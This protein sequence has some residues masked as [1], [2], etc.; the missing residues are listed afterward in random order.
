MQNLSIFRGV[1]EAFYGLVNL[2]PLETPHMVAKELVKVEFEKLILC[3]LLKHSAEFI[4]GL[5]SF[6]FLAEFHLGGPGDVWL[7]SLR[8]PYSWGWNIPFDFVKLDFK[9]WVLGIRFSF[10]NSTKIRQ[11][12]GKP[13][14][15]KFL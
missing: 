9:F 3:K 13:I 10:H 4:H 5:A 2:L 14:N 7:G 8:Y 1:A 11:K 15:R 12:I 6:I